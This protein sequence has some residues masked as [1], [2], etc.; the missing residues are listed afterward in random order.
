MKKIVTTLLLTLSA[1]YYAQAA[2]P[3][4][5][6][7]ASK[8][9]NQN[10]A[11]REVVNKLA[12]KHDA[13]VL[14][15]AESP[16]E[17]KERL[18]KIKPRYVAVVDMPENIGRDYVIEFHHTSRD[19]DSDIY[20]DFMWGIITGYDAEAAMRMVD[21]STEPLVVKDAVA[22]IMELNSAKWFDNYAWIDDH[23]K[24]LW[25]EK[26]GFDGEI[27]TGMVAPEEV[28]PKFTELYAEYDPDLIVTAAHATQQNLEMPYSLGNLK[29]RNGKLY[30]KD[31][32][33]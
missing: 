29:P 11:W 12:T 15:F 5:V 14:L 2:N 13:E 9:V 23:T 20:A 24:G 4:Y 10:E 19:I 27:R 26:R 32:F 3:E 22:T 28:L 16:C 18:Q 31:R 30:A 17:T 8:S 6:V 1:L 25:G 33:T 7:I 21:N